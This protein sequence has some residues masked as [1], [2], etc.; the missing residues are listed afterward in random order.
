MYNSRNRLISKLSVR[1]A[2]RF[3][4][5]ERMKKRGDV[6]FRCTERSGSKKILLVREKGLLPYAK[7]DVMRRTLGL[8]A[9]IVLALV[10][11]LNLTGCGSGGNP[12]SYML[13]GDKE[14]QAFDE[15]G[16]RAGDNINTFF[17]DVVKKI[18]SKKLPSES[19]AKQGADEIIKL[20]KD[21]I[22]S[23]KSA[24]GHYAKILKLNNPG[25]Y[26]E[27]AKLIVDYIDVSI[28]M[29]NEIIDYFSNLRARLASGKY[30][31]EDFRSDLQK[32]AADIQT[33][34]NESNTLRQKADELKSENS[35]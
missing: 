6:C 29:I 21:G 34:T 10:T 17:A 19:E 22:A 2:I 25:K 14:L 30:N 7:G 26:G 32:F 16:G 15:V 28:S 1:T 27:Y 20:L 33:K 35:L 8:V 4:A 18:E 31:L 11:A 12:K 23:A 5:F 13:K 3:E 9:T 24:R